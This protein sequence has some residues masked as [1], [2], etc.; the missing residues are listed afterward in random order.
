[1]AE[2]SYEQ[3]RALV[4][5]ALDAA[6]GTPAPGEVGGCWIRDLYDGSVV[7]ENG[8]KTWRQGYTITDGAALLS[9][10]AKQVVVA[11]AEIGS[12]VE[13]AARLLGEAADVQSIHDALG[14]CQPVAEAAIETEFVPLIERAVRRDNTVPLKLIR[15]GWGA[16]GYYGAGMLEA[17]GPKV[18][19]RGTKMYWNH[20][21]ATEEAERPERDLRDL[22]AELTGDARWDANGPKGP[23][24]YA[25]AKVFGGFR[26]SIDELAPHIGVSIRALGKARHGE[27]EGRKGPVIESIVAAK[28]VDFVTTPGAGGEILT[29]FEAARSR[30]EQSPATGEPM[31]EAQAVSETELTEVRT[32]L[33]EL[34]T[35]NARLREAMTLTAARDFAAQRLA[36]AAIPAPTRARLLESLVSDPP[37]T[38]AGALDREAYGTRI[39][40]AVKAELAYINALTGGA[41]VT[42]MGGAPTFEISEADATAKLAESFKRLGYDEATA[43]AAAAGRG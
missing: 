31:Q 8:G 11:Y 25:D 33:A 12:A 26:E 27:A 30:S 42:G 20:P 14:V 22:A 37:I 9:A 28:S 36:A 29:L 17:D 35:E 19:T 3:R 43:K 5:G 34:R 6:C 39:D 18:F 38:D 10:D 7:F 13:E 15:P 40:E 1:M 2:L 4:Q 24:L 23:G 21:T 16:S 41:R 32:Q